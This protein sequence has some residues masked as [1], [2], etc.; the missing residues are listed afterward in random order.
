MDPNL[1]DLTSFT[2]FFGTARIQSHIPVVAKVNQENDGGNAEAYNCID[3]STAS[4]KVVVP[5]I[6]ADFYGFYTS[7]TIQNMS[8]STGTI[9]ITYKSD[10]TY[11][12]PTNTSIQVIRSISPLGQYN[13]W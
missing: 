6:Q 13:S 9:T 3:A 7:L 11:S 5:L 8:D 12:L 4:K 2:R 10:G 1:S